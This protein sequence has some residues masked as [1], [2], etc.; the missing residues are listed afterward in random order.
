M[1][2]WCLPRQ[3]GQARPQTT[4]PQVV[5][6]RSEEVFGIHRCQERLTFFS[7]PQAEFP[8]F[9]TEAVNPPVRRRNSRRY[10]WR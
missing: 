7:V 5:A 8:S 10:R 2:W 9:G 1:G 3:T 6:D 4:G